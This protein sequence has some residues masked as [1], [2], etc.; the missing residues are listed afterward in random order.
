ME[1]TVSPTSLAAAFA[2]LPD[3]RRAAS[4]V[5]PLNAILAMTVSAILAH[6]LSVLAIAEWG[7]DQEP[8]LLANLGFPTAK[9]PCQST[10]Q[11]LFAKLDGDALGAA[12]TT[13][14]APL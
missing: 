14:F 5:Y 6:C 10:L 11:R 2:D 9:T 7:A 8:A 1:S 3:P 12:L 4:V 13:V